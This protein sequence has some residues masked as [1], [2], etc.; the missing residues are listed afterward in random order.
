ML[1]APDENTYHGIPLK[2]S[3]GSMLSWTL[4][5]KQR[6]SANGLLE[7]KRLHEERI[8]LFIFMRK[9]DPLYVDEDRCVAKACGTTMEKIDIALQHTWGFPDNIRMRGWW[10]KVPHCSCNCMGYWM[11][12]RSGFPTQHAEEFREEFKN[13][14]AV[15]GVRLY[16]S[17][18]PVHGEHS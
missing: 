16:N 15:L 8:N 4:L 2:C 10:K 3:D 14:R 7:L 11:F 1:T 18:C 5:S 13:A 6:I 9:M 17:T 12:L